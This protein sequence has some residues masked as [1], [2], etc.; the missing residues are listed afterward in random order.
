VTW[1]WLHCRLL[2]CRIGRALL[3]LPWLLN[4]GCHWP[5]SCCCSRLR[6]RLDRVL[7][8]LLLLLW[9]LRLCCS[10]RTKSARSRPG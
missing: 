6:R 1:C 2:H 8:L 3:L 5:L 9:L 4:L 10:F 7:L